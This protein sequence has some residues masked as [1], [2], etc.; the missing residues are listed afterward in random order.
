MY[1]PRTLALYI[2][3]NTH[4]FKGLKPFLNHFL[5]PR[6]GHPAKLNQLSG[7]K[8][9]WSRRWSRNKW[10]LSQSFRGPWH[11][12]ENSSIRPLCLYGRVEATQAPSQEFIKQHLR[13]ALGVYILWSVDELWAE[14]QALG[15]ANTRH[16]S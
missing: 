3:G 1:S 13:T 7:K 15:L 9:P 12:Q 4:L 6:F 2:A 14:F 10:L 8:G 11:R 5:G 16:Y